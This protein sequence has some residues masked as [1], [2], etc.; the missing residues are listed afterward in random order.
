MTQPPRNRYRVQP[1]PSG[2][3]LREDYNDSIEAILSNNFGPTAPPVL[4]G[5]MDW[6]DTSTSPAIWRKR[7][8]DNQRWHDIATIDP[9]NGIQFMV[10]GSQVPSL[11]QSQTF[12]QPQTIRVAN[13]PGQLSIG[14]TSSSSVVARLPFFGRNS[15]Q[16][17]VN[18][19]V[20]V[21]QIT[22]AS[23]GN[24]RF[25]FTIE[26]V[27][28]GQTRD[29]I[30]ID[31]DRTTVEGTFTASSL[32]QGGVPISNIISDSL[33]SLD[34]G[35]GNFTQNLNLTT[36][37]STGKAYRF[38]GNTNRVV[39]VGSAPRDFSYALVINDSNGGANLTFQAAS[40][41]SFRNSSVRL[42]GVANQSPQAALVWFNGGSRV[43]I[44]GD[45]T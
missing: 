29:V 2:L 20:L 22:Q 16:Q 11:S 24:E 33:Q 13:A 34:V 25:T 27:R 39:T 4:F 12:T 45:N 36:Q 26:V 10:G 43:N 37:E 9:Q 35:S 21:T 41:V 1:N 23:A 18:G 38:T 28:N 31:N 42:T 8:L 7:S 44:R 32:Q 3:R 40:G 14:S 30:T 19:A 6:L 15:N 5:G 17:T